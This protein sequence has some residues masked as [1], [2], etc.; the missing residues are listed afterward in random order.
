MLQQVAK[1][2]IIER[3]KFENPWWITGHIVDEYNQMQRRLYF[4]LFKSLAFETEVRRALIMMGPRRV[5][6]TVMLHHTVEE[7]IKNGVEPNKIIFI[8][9]ENPIYNNMGLEQL[10]SYSREAI[11]EKDSEG[12][13]VIFDEIQYL[14]NWE[15][16]L[17]SLVDSYKNSKFIVSGSAAAALKLKS[18]ESGAGRFTDFLLPPLTFHEYIHLLD[19]ERI[20]KQTTVDWKGSLQTFFT[21]SHIDELN[22]RFIDFINTGGYPEVIFSEKIRANPGRY[23]RHD[24]IDKVLLRDLPS[25]YG[26]NDVQ[27]L[28]SLFTTIAY[29]SRK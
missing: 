1:N 2:Q 18:N 15:V 16:H 10:F 19:L 24:I 7:L 20:I 14:K 25:L 28:N 8:T 5:G 21:S 11:G 17:K 4:S 29:N 27:E 9:V 22:S 26:I 12:W 13:F 3:I 23:I 6:K